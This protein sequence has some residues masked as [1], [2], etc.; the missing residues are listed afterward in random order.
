MIQPPLVKVESTREACIFDAYKFERAV[1]TT[2]LLNP[3]FE[4]T[5]FDECQFVINKSI[6]KP[7]DLKK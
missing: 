7:A 4:S 5:Y 2:N 1:Y 3:G 6:S